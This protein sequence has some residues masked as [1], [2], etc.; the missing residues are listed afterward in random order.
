MILFTSSASRGP[1]RDVPIKLRWVDRSA[2]QAET[3]EDDGFWQPAS[4][5]QLRQSPP[6][7]LVPG[8][9][10]CMDDATVVV[11][12]MVSSNQNAGRYLG[13]EAAFLHT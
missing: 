6:F 4:R 13:Q 12:Q 11:Q 2:D 7:D 8:F 5:F 9:G 3:V 10:G 1:D